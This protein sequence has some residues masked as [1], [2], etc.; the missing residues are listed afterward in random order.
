MNS[1]I[2][3]RRIKLAGHCH[4]HKELP[5]GTLVLWELTSGQGHRSQGGAT[6]TFVDALKEDTGAK[7]AKEIA[8][9]AWKIG[10][11]GGIGGISVCG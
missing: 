1:E 4:R 8:Q 7:T 2:A 9:G 5:A 10:M 6:K 3:T 11:T